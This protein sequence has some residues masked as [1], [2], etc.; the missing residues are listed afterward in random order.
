MRLDFPRGQHVQ[1][2]KMDLQVMQTQRE[3]IFRGSMRTHREP[4]LRES[5]LD[6]REF[7]L[8]FRWKRD[9]F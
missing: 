6:Q 7:P 4:D 2:E 8:I 3:S 5:H 9:I 1:R